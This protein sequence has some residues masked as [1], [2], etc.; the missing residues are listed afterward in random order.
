[1]MAL[2]MALPFFCNWLVECLE[3]GL[4]CT[5]GALIFTFG[6]VGGAYD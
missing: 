1:M 2:L 4:A 5:S 3:L 6:S